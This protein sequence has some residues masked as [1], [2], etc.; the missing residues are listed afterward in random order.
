MSRRDRRGLH[1]LGAI[2][3]LLFIGALILRGSL[4]LY[5]PPGDG[6]IVDV[7]P[8]TGAVTGGAVQLVPSTTSP[9]FDDVELFPG[10]RSSACLTIEHRGDVGL[11]AV[12]LQLADVTGPE[13]LLRALRLEVA[14]G[15]GAA[16]GCEGF[17][18]DEVIEGPL[19][20]LT[21]APAPTSWSSWVPEDGEEAVFRLT[22][23]L[24]EDAA[25]ALQG[26]TATS[27]FQWTATARPSGGGFAERLGLLLSAV[28]RDALLP[29][30]LLV[31]L[32]VLFLGIQDR[33][34]RQDPKLALAAVVEEPDSFMD[35][36]EVL[37]RELGPR[38]HL[39]SAGAPR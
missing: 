16:R 18:A 8:E 1:L 19:R 17:R 29:L 39:T 23:S 24:A 11:D 3:A 35:P 27:G 30:L 25:D 2:A 34:D 10:E 28:A 20:D 26:A 32:G 15:A 33:I 12:L 4:G 7:D 22:L 14:R 5:V 31:V 38:R 36:E 9:L 21:G 13:P 37:R 6:G